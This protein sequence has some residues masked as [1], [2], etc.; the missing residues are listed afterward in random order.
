ML[1]VVDDA[2]L[3]KALSM[4]DAENAGDPAFLRAGAV[5]GPRERVLSGLVSGW[6]VRLRPDPS[7]ALLLAARGAHLHRWEHPRAEYPAGRAGYLRWR[8]A[9]YSIQAAHLGRVL[10]AAGADPPTISRATE[11]V[12]K[13][14]PRTDPEAQAL[15]DALCLS[16]VEADMA[17][18]SGRTDEATMTRILR[19]TWAKMSDAAHELALTLIQDEG[20]RRLVERALAGA[21]ASP[22][23]E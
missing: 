16:F 3:Q 8:T 9:L 12:A 23:S 20:Q 5:E 1:P 7:A 4:I 19:K 22:S 18:L 2:T 10:E 6:V 13:R 14:V 11:L 15:E 17:A 21:P